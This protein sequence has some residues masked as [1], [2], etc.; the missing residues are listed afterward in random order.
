MRKLYH[1]PEEKREAQRAYDRKRNHTEHRRAYDR[2]R[3]PRKH[4]ITQL[5]LFPETRIC[6]TCKQE[7]SLETSFDKQ[8]SG[9]FGYR[10]HCKTCREAERKAASP[11]QE[12]V[13]PSSKVCPKCDPPTEKP[14][15]DFPLNK[16]RKDGHGSYCS[17][18][19][20]KWGRTEERKSAEREYRKQ[21]RIDPEYR[22]KRQE[23]NNQWRREHPE[24]QQELTL[25]RNARKRAATT[26]RVSF[27]RILERDG[28]WCYICEASIDPN[29]KKRSPESL[30]FDHFVPLQPRTGNPQGTHSEDNIHPAHKVCNARKANKPFS[31][32]TDFDRSGIS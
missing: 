10:A 21:K 23:K 6:K 32:L 8:K 11:R 13:I 3:R 9:K 5:P 24:S 20:S 19:V 1:T 12:W 2:Q 30:T 15:D 25:R 18:C 7:K 4:P 27:K 31:A 26:E 16:N 14:I 22:I 29:A 28:Y 17:E